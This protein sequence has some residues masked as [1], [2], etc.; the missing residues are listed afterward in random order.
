[1]S[2]PSDLTLPVRPETLA[3]V[4]SP[5]RSI[6]L[7]GIRADG[8]FERL[9]E[10]SPTFP[11]LCAALGSQFVAFS[12][13]TG[14]RIHSL[15][16]DR[17]DPNATVVEFSVGEQPEKHEI[18]LIELQKRL[19]AVLLSGDE[20]VGET[21]PPNP[22]PEDVQGLIGFRYLLLAPLF[23]VTL[24]ELIV[25]GDEEPS[26]RIRLGTLEEELRIEALRDVIRARVRHELTELEKSSG[27]ALDDKIIEEAKVAWKEGNGARVMDLLGA[28]LGP[29]TMMLRTAEAQNMD[30]EGRAKIARVLALLG[31][32]QGERDAQTAEDILRV[33]VQWA[34]GNAAASDVFLSMG[35]LHLTTASDGQAIGVLR[36][37]MSLGATDKDVMPLLAR[38]YANRGKWV[39]CALCAEAAMAAGA[40]GADLRT[41]R[42]QAAKTL[43]SP[44]A[45]FR[46]VV[47]ARRA[48]EPTDH[49]LVT[50]AS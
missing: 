17:R 40:E 44:W 5:R 48:D 32:A 14:I 42:D 41:L 6:S 28:W 33:A 1:M 19:C 35:R 20:P 37:A 2:P 50:S 13:I 25:G 10:G 21:L 38:S 3:A 23:G 16:V 7:D 34:Q 49:D 4:G 22:S 24:E 43:G 47:P 26:L 30:P 31:E 9:G 27:F 36:R 29:L 8:W 45:A 18:S 39:A 12:V 46:E 11:Q 15:M